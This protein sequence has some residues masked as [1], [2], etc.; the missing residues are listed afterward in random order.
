MRKY[1]PIAAAILLMIAAGVSVVK[2]KKSR[3]MKEE[4]AIPSH[5]SSV[6]SSVPPQIQKVKRCA[7]SPLFL[8]TLKIPQPVMIDLSQKRFKGVALLYGEGFKKVLHPKFWEKYG[9]FGTYTIDRQG[10]IYLVP[11]PFISIDKETFAWQK[12]LYRIDTRTGKLDKWIDFDEITAKAD[13]PYGLSAIVYDCQD[14]TLW[15]AALD[16][17]DY[18]KERGRIYHIDIKTGKVIGKIEG[19]DALSLELASDSLGER[20]YLLIG[21]ARRNTLYLYDIKKRNTHAPVK[22][23]ELPQEQERIRKIRVTGMNRLL[24]ETIPFSYSLITAS[25]EQD[26][27]VYDVAYDKNGRRWI[28]RKQ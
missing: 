12:S 18:R 28:L 24:I 20:R 1:L 11:M 2:L 14:D 23:F 10:N 15:V 26:R 16:R 19:I 25:S 17:S 27:A 4:G 5:T 9:H 21:S 22:V 3:H 13:N 6:T 8:Q 7:K